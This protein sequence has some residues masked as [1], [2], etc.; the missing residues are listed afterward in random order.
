[1]NEAFAFPINAHRRIEDGL[2]IA[3]PLLLPVADAAQ[4]DD[5]MLDSWLASLTPAQFER[6]LD[7]LARSDLAGSAVA[8]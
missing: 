3:S 8:S 1:M 2:P 7:S 6:I 4:P 5:A